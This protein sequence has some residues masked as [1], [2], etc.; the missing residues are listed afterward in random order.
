MKR[1]AVNNQK[2]YVSFPRDKRLDSIKKFPSKIY[3]S[4]TDSI[5]FLQFDIEYVTRLVEKSERVRPDPQSDGFEEPVLYMYGCT[6]SGDSVLARVTGFKPYFYI[7]VDHLY[8]ESELNDLKVSMNKALHVDVQGNTDDDQYVLSVEGV[9]QYHSIMNYTAYKDDFFVKITLRIP[10]YVP[11]LRHLLNDTTRVS[12]RQFQTFEAD[13]LFVLRYMIDAGIVGCSWVKA[14]PKRYVIIPDSNRISRCQLEISLDYRDLVNLGFTGEYTRMAPLRICSFDIECV[15]AKGTFPVP[16][17]DSVIQIA[18]YVVELGSEKVINKNVFVLKGCTPIPGATIFGFDTEEELLKG[19]SDFVNDID[20]DIFTGYNIMNF[21][22]NYLITRANTLKVKD[23]GRFSRLRKSNVTMKQGTF[24]SKAVGT[25]ESFELIGLEG[26]I[27]FDMF[28]VIQRDYKLRSYTLNFVSSNFLGDQKEDVHY[29]DIADLHNGSPDDRNRIAVYCLKDTYLPIRLIKKLMSLVNGVEMCRVT[30]IPLSYLLPRGQQVKVITQLYRH[31]ND[32]HFLIPFYQRPS[33]E[34]DKYVGATVINP[35]KGFYRDPISVLD[36]SSLYPSIM[37]SH[38]L[39]YSTLIEGVKTRVDVKNIED[40]KTSGEQSDKN[41]Y[42][43]IVKKCLEKHLSLDDVELSPNGDLFV[44]SNKQ[45]G[46]L[47]EILEN[48]LAARKQ[49]KK[50]MAAEK[51]EFKIKVLNGRQLAL[52]ISANSVYGFTGAQV[53]K[54]PCMQIASSV[55]SYG[56]TMIE[57]TK[58]TVETHY[59]I[60]NGFAYDAKVVYGDTDSVM[61]KFGT[62]DLKEAI[63]VGKEA[64]EYVTSKFPKPINLE[65]EK[66]FWPYL[67]ISKKRYAGVFWCNAEKYDHLDTKGIETVRRDNCMLV[68]YVIE[69]CLDLILLDKEKDNITRAV[70]FVKDTIRELLQNKLDLSMLIISKTLS[71]ESYAAKQA[72]VELANRMRER[73]K[74]VLINLG[75]R[76]PYVIVKSTKEAR[77]YEKAEDPM[78]VLQKDIP[79]DFE[80]YIENQMRKPLTRI[81]RPILGDK[82]NELFEGEHT[83]FVV[84]TTP[85]EASPLGKFIVKQKRC[86]ECR[87]VVKGSGVLCENCKQKT[88]EILVKKM[89][90]VRESELEYN[91]IMTQCQDCMISHHRDIICGNRDCPIFYMRTKVEKAIKQK[92]AMIEDFDW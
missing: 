50:D 20:V 24:Q 52:K 55:T 57:L 39:C 12:N 89:K 76:I 83:R 16:E 85:V 46:I 58:N 23:F 45:K 71:K 37:I 77:A 1:Q 61:V 33:G 68:K 54:L 14:P 42:D 11:M 48:L 59:S 2:N 7:S 3:N 72:H 36:F 21:D 80:Y 35:I 87:A 63:R 9:T 92:R 30:G 90:D 40:L 8:T 75:D 38:N 43:Q 51:D 6:S 47:P 73:D 60:K 26:R 28:Q 74:S 67:L 18:N 53:G 19:W 66:V 81:F 4:Q 44:R 62:S 79:I 25:R 65:F 82:V 88:G 56:R 70:Q 86:V 91:A 34:G 29:S 78:Y 69:R 64:A 22:F 17:K 27:P 32:K 10:K 41:A 49:A 13:I 15:S 31:A 5:E 84:Q